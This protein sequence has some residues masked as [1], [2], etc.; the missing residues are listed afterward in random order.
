MKIRTD[1]VTNSS[2]SS[3]ILSFKDEKSIK[4]TL[5]EQIPKDIESGWSAGEDGYLSQLLSEIGKADRLTNDDIKKLV[6]YEKKWDIRW[7]LRNTLEAKKRMSR[8]EANDYLDSSEGQKMINEMLSEKIKDVM[9]KI[10]T[11]KVVVQVE[12]GDGG[13]GEDGV[14]ENEILPNLDCTV[15]SFS[16]H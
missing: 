15:T 5:E 11:D 6:E 7:E 2:S 3:F 14:L 13:E 16:H 10:G 1:Y 4:K 12:H 8:S 9:D